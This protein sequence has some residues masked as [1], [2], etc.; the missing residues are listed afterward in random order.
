M[1]VILNHWMRKHSAHPLTESG[2]TA[3]P[4]DLTADEIVALHCKYDV[5]ITTSPY[6]EIPILWLDDLGRRF[7]RR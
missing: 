3:G 2:L 1:R 5:M 7:E 4:Q 6:N